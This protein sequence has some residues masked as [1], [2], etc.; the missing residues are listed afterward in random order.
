MVEDTEDIIQQCKSPSLYF[1]GKLSPLL[2]SKSPT[3]VPLLRINLRIQTESRAY[4]ATILWRQQDFCRGESLW[5]RSWKW[6][7]Q[8][9]LGR[10]MSSVFLRTPI[11]HSSRTANSSDVECFCQLRNIDECM[12]N[13][14]LM[15]VQTV[16]YFIRR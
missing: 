1:S 11:N 3:I 9:C 14:S 4:R 7:Q 6:L 10:L 2:C 8:S 12:I 16:V 5:Q 15:F 13:F